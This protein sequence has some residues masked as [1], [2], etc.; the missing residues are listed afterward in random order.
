[1]TELLNE[2]AARKTLDIDVHGI[3]VTTDWKR[4]FVTNE[5]TEG[6]LKVYAA[7]PKLVVV[8][9]D[10]E[11]LELVCLDTPVYKPCGADCRYECGQV[12]IHR[13]DN[14]TIQIS[15]S[16]E[17]TCAFRVR[18]NENALVIE[19]TNDSLAFKEGTKITVYVV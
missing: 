9:D 3:T 7:G 11:R 16:L 6:T 5:P 10:P 4:V 19:T 1:M 2:Q 18:A 15:N 8:I 17:P 12:M 14:L 13:V